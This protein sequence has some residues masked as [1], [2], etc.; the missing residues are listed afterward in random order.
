MLQFFAL[1]FPLFFQVAIDK[2][3]VHKGMANLDALVIGPVNV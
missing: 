2:V 1:V 3:L